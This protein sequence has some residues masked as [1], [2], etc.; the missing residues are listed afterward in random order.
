M[1]GGL[2]GWH[3]LL[4]LVVIA[5]VVVPIVLVRG[6]ASRRAAIVNGDAVG[7]T[8]VLAVLSL[9]LSFF[10]SVAAVICGHIALAQIHR[11]GER[12]WGIAV[13]GLWIGYTGLVVGVLSVI[14][15][16]LVLGAA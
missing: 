13:A 11:T 1:L 7:P 4:I 12:G 6:A 10:V 14:A 3:L 9:V 2:Q 15:A 5:A 8:N 16:V